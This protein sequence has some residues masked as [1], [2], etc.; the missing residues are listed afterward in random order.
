MGS[1]MCI[2]DRLKPGGRL[3]TCGSTTGHDVGI[4]LR[5]VFY[6]RLS[7][8]GSTMGSKG[9][10]FHIL[11]L[12]EAGKLRPVLDRTLPLTEAARAHVLLAERAQFGKIVLVP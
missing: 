4:D 1:E 7:I 6:K 8:L 12:V 2:R 5:H 9:S 10:L 3:V 11:G